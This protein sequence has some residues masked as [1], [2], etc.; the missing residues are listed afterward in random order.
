MPTPSSRSGAVQAHDNGQEDLSIARPP[1]DL[2]QQVQADVNQ[3]G[4]ELVP[5]AGRAGSIGATM[6]DLPGSEDNSVTV[7][8]P[9]EHAQKAPSQSLVRIKSRDGR[10]YLGIVTAGPF[11]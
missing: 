7:V 8:L 10:Q 6:F 11:A 4:G 1:E 2:F 3:A 5:D 9:R